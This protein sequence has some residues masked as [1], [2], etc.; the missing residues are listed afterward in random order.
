MALNGNVPERVRV[1]FQQAQHL[2]IYS[3]LQFSLLTVAHT[4]ALIAV[5]CALITRWREERPE[6]ATQTK[7]LPGLKELLSIAV[8]NGWIRDCDPHLI[9]QIPVLRNGL[10]HGEYML[11]PFDTLHLVGEYGKLIQKLYLGLE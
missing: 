7:K 4:Q 9:D 3:N 8:N 1:Q 2:L 5:E 10:A 6:R 11:A